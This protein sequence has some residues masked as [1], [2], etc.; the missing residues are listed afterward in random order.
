MRK[1]FIVL[2]ILMSVKTV[3][4]QNI[5]V[6]YDLNKNREYVTTTVEFFKPDKWGSTFF[7]VDF[8]F[9]AVGDNVGAAYFEIAREL[10]FWEGPISYHTEYNGGTMAGN[11]WLNG[12]TYSW[13]KDDFSKGFSFTAMHKYISYAENKHNF[14]LT[15]VWY[16]HF[17]DKKV[18]FTGFM[19]W[20]KE[21]LAYLGTD[22]IFLSEPQLW[23]NLNTVWEGVNLSLGGELEISK[24]FY[25]SDDWEFCPA[26]GAKWTF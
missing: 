3:S 5:Q 2:V 4:A 22:F 11:M 16:M 9:N 25:S 1:I 14:Q 17:F 8:D 13:N 6:L 10:K 19:D 12:A 24:N 20:W 7:F 15:G 18:T 26:L 21:E 23:Y